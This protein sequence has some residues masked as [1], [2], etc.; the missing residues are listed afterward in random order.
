MA[1]RI[2]I[3][4]AEEIVEP[5]EIDPEC[6]VTPGV[7]VDIIVTGTGGEWKWNWE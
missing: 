7:F 1:S 6:V 3:V 2:T 4:H 5:G